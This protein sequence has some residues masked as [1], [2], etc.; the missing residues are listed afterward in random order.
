MARRFATQIGATSA[1]E[2]ILQ[3]KNLSKLGSTPS[4]HEVRPISRPWSETMV[5]ISP[6]KHRKHLDAERVFWVWSAHFWIW[7]RRPLAQG[8]GVDPCLLKTYF[9][10]VGAIRAESPQTRDSQCLSCLR[11]ADSQFKRGSLREH[12]QNDS[13]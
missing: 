1:R 12:L 8:V 3:K 10:N 4:P 9:H 2:S 13:R 11:S 7:S 6:P 5:P